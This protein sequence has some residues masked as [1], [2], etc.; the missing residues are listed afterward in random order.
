MTCF[1]LWEAPF[2]LAA[3]RR[4]AEPAAWVCTWPAAPSLLPAGRSTW[5]LEK[6]IWQQRTD[7]GPHTLSLQTHRGTLEEWM[8]CVQSLVIATVGCGQQPRLQLPSACLRLSLGR[9]KAS[10][11]CR[12]GVLKN[13]YKCTCKTCSGLCQCQGPLAPGATRPL[14][15]LIL[16]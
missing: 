16:A 12:P 9:G 10:F 2:S 11:C 5:D 1:S 14:V 3:R 7:A 4:P 15:L 13:L 6:P 8:Q